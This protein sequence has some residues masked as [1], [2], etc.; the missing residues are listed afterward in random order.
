M[1]PHFSECD[2]GGLNTITGFGCLL[3]YG[4]NV[5]GFAVKEGHSVHHEVNGEFR[6]FFAEC[7]PPKGFVWSPDRK[8]FVFITNKKDALRKIEEFAAQIVE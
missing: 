5:A 6:I 1:C 4:R 2:S 3:V 7:N 8:K